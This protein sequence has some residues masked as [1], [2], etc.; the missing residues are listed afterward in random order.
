MDS[1]RRHQ[2]AQNA[3][4][5]WFITQYEEW[6][7]PNSHLLSVV[8]LIIFLLFLSYFGYTRWSEWNK[9]RAWGKY[10]A[11]IHS[12]NAENELESLA[13]TARG[14][15]ADQARLT[16]AQIQLSDASNQ[17]FTDKP[18]AV[19]RLE[20]V[21]EQ[22]QR[23]QRS[24]DVSL[25][26]QASYGL[27]QAWESLAAAR[28]GKN[29]LAEA[30]NEYKKIT[31]QFPNEFLGQKAKKQLALISRSSTKKFFEFAA[32]KIAETPKTEDFKVEINKTDPFLDGPKSFDPQKALGGDSI[33][34]GEFQERIAEITNPSAENTQPAENSPPVENTQPAENSPPAENTQPAE[35]NKPFP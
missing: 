16:L 2:L 31:E 24:T 10:Y 35:K 20:K 33:L 9:A 14:F 30:E 11:A 12:E 25:C 17:L 22:F 7:Q 19:E 34:K 21:I 5:N 1:N 6:I 18:K 15:F 29:D 28:V 8:I 13:E 23:V 26:L 4:A 32:A 27:A 3:L